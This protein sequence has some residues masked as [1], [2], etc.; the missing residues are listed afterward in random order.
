[1]NARISVVTILAAMIFA[2]GQV[3]S[4]T[5]A[6]DFT[7]DSDGTDPAWD[8]P[9][10]NWTLGGSPTLLT[11]DADDNVVFDSDLLPIG[12]PPLVELNGNREVLSATFDGDTA[13]ML[14][15]L[16]G[17]TLS[18][19]TGNLTADLGNDFGGH[20]IGVDVTLQ[21]SGI[22]DIDASGSGVATL[23]IVGA[24][25]ESGGSFGFTKTGTGELELLG[26]NTYTG[27]TAINA[28]TVSLLDALALQNS[29][30]V[31]NVDDGLNI[32]N[33]P[34][35]DVLLGG[36]SGTGNLDIVDKN[37]IVGSNNANTSYSGVISG[38]GALVKRGTGELTLS[39]INTYSG[40][41]IIEGG[42]V[43]ISQ[44]ANLGDASAD[45]FIN[46]GLTDATL[47]VTDSHETNRDVFITA[48]DATL[49]V[50]AGQNYAVHGTVTGGALNKV[51]AGT[52][53]LTA[54]NTY[55]GG[56]TIDGGTLA[57]G[58]DNAAGTGTITVLGSTI[59]YA[60]G[61]HVTNAIDLQNDATFNVDTGAPN[62]S[63]GIGETDGS[64]G[65]TK[66]GAGA[67]LLSGANTFSGGVTLA[68][69]VLGLGNSS[70]AGTGNITVT[71][72]GTRIDYADIAMFRNIDLQTDTILS[73]GALAAQQVGSIGETG[74]SFG[75]T[76]GGSGMLT[77]RN[78]NT[79][80]GGL[81]IEEGTVM[82]RDSNTAAGTGGI[83][84]QGGDILLVLLNVANNIDLQD[85]TI[86]TVDS[87]SDSTLS[88]VI[89]ETGG[90]FGFRKEGGGTLTL[91]GDN[92]YTGDTIV[93]AGTLSVGDG[94]TTGS[95]LGDVTLLTSLVFNRSNDL[96]FSGIITGVGDV[97][98][99]GSG[100]LTLTGA[101]SFTN[102]VT[103]NSGELGLA[104]SSA[105]G[106]GTITVVDGIINYADSVEIANLVD[107]Q[108]DV[109]L[110]IDSGTATQSGAFIESGGSFRVFIDGTDGSAAIRLAGNNKFSDGLS[111]VNGKVI[112][113]HNNAAGT[114]QIR[115]QTGTVGYED[116]IAIANTMAL[117]ND[118][119]LDVA[120]G[121]AAQSGVISEN[122][123]SFGFTKTGDGT[124][125]LTSSSGNTHTGGTTLQGGTLLIS[126]ANHLGTATLTFDGGRLGILG[127]SLASDDEIPNTMVF[128]TNG[129]G[130]EILGTFTFNRTLTHA[131]PLFKT[132]DGELILTAAN[133]YT[134]GT[135]IDGGTV[136]AE[137]DNN[138]GDANGP[139]SFDGGTLRFAAGFDLAA[140]RA[141]TLNAGGG[142][143][144][145]NGFDTSIAQE[146]AGTGGLTKTGDGTLTLA[147]VNTYTGGT[148]IDVG[149]LAAAVDTYLGEAN[150]SLSFDG[151]TLRFGAA[152]DLA[153][154]RAV[155]LNGGGGTID[156]NG[157]DT[158]VAQA[159]DGTGALTKTGAGTL[160]LD[161]TSTYTGGT[162]IEEGV[163]SINLDTNLGDPAG[164]VTLIN[165]AVIQIPGSH[166]TGRDF[167]LIG[168]GVFRPLGGDTYQ[169][170]GSIS[171]S[172]PL[173]TSSADVDGSFGTLRPWGANT[174]TGGTVIGI[175]TRVT[176]QNDA[177]LGD[178][179]GTVTMLGD[180]A[181][182]AD[183][184]HTTQRDFSLMGTL[185]NTISTLSGRVYTIDGVISGGGSVQKIGVG[186][187]ILTN[188]NTFTG[189]TI[190]NSGTIQLAHS[191]ALQNST[192]E[193]NNNSGLDVTTL[194]V[195]PQVNLGG[196]SGGG[197]L[198]LGVKTLNVGSNDE[199]TTYSGTL[200][201]T[202][203]ALF[204]Q[205]DGILSL[206]GAN[207]YDGGT[208]INSG[209]LL[210]N[211]ASGSATG[212]GG[213]TVGSLGTLGG[214][215]SAAGFTNV[216][217]GTVSP[218]A[219]V[220]VLTLDDVLFKSGSTLIIELAGD[221]GVA[222]VDFD[223][224]LV[225]NGVTIDPSNTLEVSLLGA[226]TPSL[227]DTFN[228]LSATSV[229]GTFDFENLPTLDDVLGWDVNYTA[230]DVTLEVV[231]VVLPGDFNNDGMVSI[232]DY[233]V[234]RDNLGSPTEDSINNAGDG[235]NGV[236]QADYGLWKQ[237]F[238]AVSSIFAS[239]DFAT[240]D[241]AAVP[242]PCAMQIVFGGMLLGVVGGF[243]R[244]RLPG[245]QS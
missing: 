20:F 181:L 118:A 6:A 234:W 74:G 73:T 119:I 170:I 10:G 179:S 101:N 56:T 217:G 237:N 38:T 66:T 96:T 213:V 151:G 209:T 169:I 216:S 233:T 92:T 127:G 244:R 88:G 167:E 211:N 142:T 48:L 146:I 175:N 222:G 62:H 15:G 57:L 228:I 104:H 103:L 29:T 60:D 123:G 218:G 192:V 79:F 24:I 145:T 134:G 100:K 140:T 44:D 4:T 70:A 46:S 190:I 136:T 59:D 37:L 133:T 67:L 22:W 159:I 12:P 52:L 215:G 132:G 86:I 174:Y 129:G 223:Q 77:L 130:F 55:T 9:G 25:G 243:R 155:I 122:F 138:L 205:G 82:L 164:G 97:T 81:T 188:A 31:I 172:G 191:D 226:F 229:T 194:L 149:T 108:N 176:I 144:D 165:N 5:T 245:E 210:A 200:S 220:G 152:F 121:V 85:D 214:T 43:S 1:M 36:L 128:T 212:S 162:R 68:E 76:K 98:K 28:G 230:T 116:G 11:P 94:G 27:Q 113:A 99:D 53:N 72:S 7:W 207:T 102:G 227:G 75:I 236:D 131:G 201:G 110:V 23:S 242:E 33:V 45:L 195:D 54:S 84:M 89:G 117:V 221:G 240:S 158:T 64:F 69:G 147:A 232:A 141:I 41:T 120:A 204:K 163:V 78:A 71:G 183:V 111:L 21:A 171:G 137:A 239:N 39:G 2:V 50:D 16:P 177:N 189:K 198:N 13:F 14:S 42:T 203:G 196:L 187:L 124:L 193:V 125:D 225:N 186:G 51:G 184:S 26:A 180:A 65:I 168:G 173:T 17:D 148:A 178:A 40:D 154:T 206:S 241:T 166:T 58:N 63:G 115:V 3:P 105:A 8:F 90:S 34:G 49:S 150:G 197:N 208:A 91:T 219:S 153:A 114:G 19:G 95:I 199:D 126:D 182:S 161:G 139:L 143:I 160:A 18:L 35:S 224:L 83:T 109:A 231:T 202:G 157:F 87:S 135:T 185:P 61:I 156:T 32:P 30:A 107:L 80:S 47:R 93:D 106:T 112:L 238:G 235:L